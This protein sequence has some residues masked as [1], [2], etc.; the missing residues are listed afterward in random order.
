MTIVPSVKQIKIWDGTTEADVTTLG[1]LETM[2]TGQLVPMEY[3]YI[4]LTYTGTNLTGVVY[5]TGGAGGATVATLTLAYTGS[6][7][8]S[9]TRT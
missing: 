3:D 4:A 5:K 9:I 1:S 2:N 6:V 7:L 8:D